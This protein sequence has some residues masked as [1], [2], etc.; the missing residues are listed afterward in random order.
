MTPKIGP[1]LKSAIL[2]IKTYK[3]I[4]ETIVDM[5]KNYGYA[6]ICIT[7][8]NRFNEEFIMP[9]DTV[10]SYLERYFDILGIPRNP[11]L[12]MLCADRVL[13]YLTGIATPIQT[14]SE[15]L[16]LTKQFKANPHL[17]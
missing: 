10:D 4:I 3:T 14:I 6:Y 13:L 7:F 9:S 8:L 5:E 1:A 17:F 12:R 15:I 16:K 2:G 11:S